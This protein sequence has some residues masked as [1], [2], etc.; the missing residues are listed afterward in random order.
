[1]SSRH[2]TSL[3]LEPNK[4]NFAKHDESFKESITKETLS[5]AILILQKKNGRK[6]LKL[7]HSTT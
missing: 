7:C 6:T 3:S 4:L 5:G 1:V 2:E